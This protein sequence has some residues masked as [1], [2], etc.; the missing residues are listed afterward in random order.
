[1]NFL[2]IAEDR[3]MQIDF[4]HAVTYVLSR[5]AGYGHDD[6]LIIAYASQYVD[7]ATNSGSIEF[8]DS[9]Q[10]FYHIAS[11]HVLWDKGNFR[12]TEDEE[13]WVP[14]HFLPGN[15]GAEQ[16]GASHEPMIKRL[17]CCTD[18]P[19]SRD[20]WGA[21]KAAKNEATW[22]QRLGITT[23]VY[24]D[25]F[26]HYAF[27]GV[28]NDINK[29]SA[30]RFTGEG[31]LDNMADWLSQVISEVENLGHGSALK[32]PD[33]PYLKWSYSDYDGNR[34]ERD[35]ASRFADG[36]D[37]IFYNYLIYRD[38]VSD[39]LI[40][41]HDRQLILESFRG[42]ADRDGAVRHRKWLDL[43]RDGGF[44]FGGL[45]P[46]EAASLEYI[47][48]GQGSWKFDAL[49]TK[50]DWDIPGTR[51]PYKSHFEESNWKLFHDALICH[52]DEVLQTLLPSYGLSLAL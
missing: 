24:A 25:T 16:G 4:H 20:M 33:A 36:C 7:D 2:E 9:R 50:R 6:A 15:N 14:F 11:S 40:P 1:M 46:E 18:S 13:V 34:C 43:I 44:S 27:A 48:K 32:C 17:V 10:P 49:G 26:A 45:N 52:R 12:P 37:R 42:F 41:D 21:C 29:I 51:F 28:I 23:H 38:D 3:Q 47:P 22:R 30:I 39:R 35:N 31:L 5:L 8:S 19:L